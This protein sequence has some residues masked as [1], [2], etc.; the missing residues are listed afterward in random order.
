MSQ[1]NP[2]GKYISIGKKAH[3]N[4]APTSAGTY[5]VSLGNISEDSGYAKCSGRGAICAGDGSLNATGNGSIAMGFGQALRSIYSEGVGSIAMGYGNAT[6]S[7]YSSGQGSV[8]MGFN[9]KAHSKGQCAIG[10]NNIAD[11]ND[12]YALIVGNGTSNSARSNAL[13]VDWNGNL[14]CNNIPAPPAGDGTYNLQC[15]ISSGVATYTWVAQV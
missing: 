12:T 15:T 11:N 9:V 7:L 14:V 6:E 2:Q 5:S 10:K 4:D 3:G 13:T 1:T 8:A